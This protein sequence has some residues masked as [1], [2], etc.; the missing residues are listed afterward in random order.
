MRQVS[1]AIS[2]EN[3]PEK[4]LGDHRAPS[5]PYFYKKIPQNSELPTA[6][7]DV[8]ENAIAFGAGF[9]TRNSFSP[10]EEPVSGESDILAPFENLLD[11]VGGYIGGEGRKAEVQVMVRASAI[12][13]DARY[14]TDEE[15]KW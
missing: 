3:K 11:E 15:W 1:P 14:L 10:E 8:N 2:S 6:P 4:F 12:A 13:E 9:K 7:Q 5:L